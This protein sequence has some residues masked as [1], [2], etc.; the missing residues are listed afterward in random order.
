MKTNEIIAESVE[1]GDEVKPECKHPDSK[2]VQ[3]AY[4]KVWEGVCL[5][6]G[7]QVLL[8]PVQL[9]H[10]DAEFENITGKKQKPGKGE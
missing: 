9:E 2:V 6:C 7:K 3:T 8:T 10:L 5:L 1:L 4:H